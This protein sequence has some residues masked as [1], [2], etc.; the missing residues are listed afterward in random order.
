MRSIGGAVLKPHRFQIFENPFASALASIAAFA[1]AAK[2]TGSI[3]EI[4]TVDPNHAGLQFRCKVQ[5]NIDALAPDAGSQTVHRIV[6]EFHS[7]PRSTERHRRKHRAE[8]FLLGYDRSR[9]NVAEQRGRVIQ[10][11]RRHWDG[12]LPASRS[13]GDALIDQP[14]DTLELHAGHDG[15][16]V[17]GFVERRAN[18]QRVHAILNLADQFFRDAFLH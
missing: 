8:D 15:A 10:T 4:R 3:E 2:T 1:I 5:R 16:N 18:A 9:M 7:F 13:F 17:D 11:T 6:G 12:R 14:L